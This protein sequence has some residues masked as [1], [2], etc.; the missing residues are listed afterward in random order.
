VGFDPSVQATR[1]RVTVLITSSKGSHEF[2]A[3]S[4]C[5]ETAS[6]AIHRHT[7]LRIAVNNREFLVSNEE[8]SRFRTG[9]ATPETTATEQLHQTTEAEEDTALCFTEEETNRQA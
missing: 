4:P 3:F 2:F 6:P 7:A 5:R 1:G 9:P 8:L